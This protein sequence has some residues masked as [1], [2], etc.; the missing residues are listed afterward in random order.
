LH[1]NF[2][3]WFP[4][5]WELEFQDLIDFAKKY[6]FDSVSMFGYHDEKLAWSSKLDQKVDDKEIIKRVEAMSNVLNEIYDK[7]EKARIW[8]EFTGYVYDFD[9]KNVHIRW[10]YKAPELD[11]LDIVSLENIIEWTVEIGEKVRYRK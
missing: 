5:E 7:K 2:I 10:E 4:W 8:K 9:D 3:V 11:E 1:T 6:E